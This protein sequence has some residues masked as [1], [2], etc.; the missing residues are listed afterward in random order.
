[1]SDRSGKSAPESW[2]ILDNMIDGVT[3]IDLQ[4]RI[5]YI[6][7]AT[8]L[9]HGYSMDEALGRT[10]AE[11]FLD[12]REIPKFLKTIDL[13][14]SGKSLSAEEFLAKKKD[15]TRFPTSVN[16][17]VL[18]DSEGRPHR[19]I[20]VHRDI[21]E[22]IVAEQELQVR[23]EIFRNISSSAQDAII[24]MNHDG[25]TF[26]WNE[27]AEKIFGYT[28]EEVLGRELHTLLGPER[29]HR[30]YR[31]GL[32]R[33]QESGSG[34]AVGNTLELAAMRKDGTEFPIE[35]SVS[36]VKIKG[37]WKAIGILRDITERK[38]DERRLKELNA[39]LRRSNRELADF[40]YMV[41]HD[42]QEPLRK[43]HTFGQFLMEDC[44]EALTE[45]GRD[46]ILR[47]QRAA[48]RMKDL[49]QHL[50]ELSRVRTRGSRPVAVRPREIIEKALGTLGG[51]IE[52]CGGEVT[53]GAEMPAAMA[54]PVQ[55][56]MV[57]QNLIGNA[58]KFR[59]PDRPPQVMVSAE[60]EGSELVFRVADNGIGIEERFLEKIFAAF[61]R[62]HTRDKYEGS[63]IGLSLCEKIIQ[64]HG[65]RIWAESEMGRGSIFQFTLPLA[66][67]PGLPAKKRRKRDDPPGRTIPRT[68]APRRGR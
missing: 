2:A 31:E 63:G 16:L 54:D 42:L 36:S 18:K 37:Q 46:Y 47:M 9:Q 4:G 62:L 3:I 24:M 23:E 68:G 49:I 7:R 27:A 45:E 1:M 12:E 13:L 56:E 64:R 10:P 20:A 35:L 17:S 11:L 55:I 51:R 28:K 41:S 57:F 66:S 33:F 60:V 59:S 38:R 40:T 34:P 48:L 44:A 61:Q 53:V 65:G 26:Y 6:N 30:D 8:T 32:A 15:G 50:L 14:R 29:Y 58:L 67:E 25:S 43:M 39:E 22:R 19:I 21:T 5:T 52:D